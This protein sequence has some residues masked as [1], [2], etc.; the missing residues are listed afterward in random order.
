MRDVLSRDNFYELSGKLKDLRLLSE[1]DTTKLT[2]CE[3]H[4]RNRENFPGLSLSS[5]GLYD[6][7]G[8]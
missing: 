4:K 2:V 7:K 1:K 5:R 8:I 3:I 6:K